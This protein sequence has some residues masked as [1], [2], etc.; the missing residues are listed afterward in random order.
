MSQEINDLDLGTID[1]DPRDRTSGRNHVDLPKVGGF[2]AVKGLFNKG[3]QGKLIFL[4]VVAAIVL[5][6]ATW[7]YMSV[8]APVLQGGNGET[9]GGTIHTQKNTRPTN[10]QQEEATR[11]NEEEL[12]KLQEAEPTAHP[13]VVT[14][15]N[16]D[17]GR[18]RNF[19]RPDRVSNVG[20]TT[21]DGVPVQNHTSD[22]Q[23]GRGQTARPVAQPTS[24]QIDLIKR[25]VAAE[26][27]QTPV[28]KSV[29]WTYQKPAKKED[30]GS[31]PEG[32][33]TSSTSRYDSD[34]QLAGELPSL[35]ANP[36]IRAGHQ[37]VAR[38]TMAL[39]SDVGG[40]VILEL[41]NG[42]LRKHKM[43]GKFERREEW[44]RMELTSLVGIKDPVKINAIGLDMDTVLNAVGG[45][46]DYHTMYRYGWWGIGTVLSA[47]GKAA[48]RTAD[49]KTIYVGDNI[50]QDT[51]SDT[52][53][54][55]KI[56]LG[57]LGQSVGEIMQ[58]RLN[59]PLTVSLKVNDLVGIVFMDDVCGDK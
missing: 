56:A 37:Y 28:L 13:I 30:A 25:L 59:R 57:D 4:G 39:N 29:S 54:E 1:A 40:P 45:D 46:V 10:M 31:G 58:D 21:A 35:C 20:S 32:S 42:P 48:E 3:N 19:S 5:G 2:G 14:E 49:T 33:T 44:L 16:V 27:A 9:N 36:I 15:D 55:M 17:F 18:E 50:V 7:S 12:P 24:A 52:S 23:S 34:G 43:L 26:G 11:Y 53:R 47:I 38:S 22:P 8:K 51:A 41:V 6:G